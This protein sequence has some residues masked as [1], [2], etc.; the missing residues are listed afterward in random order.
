MYD[1]QAGGMH[2]NGMLSFV[3][4]AFTHTQIQTDTCRQTDTLESA[5]A[6]LSYAAFIIKLNSVISRLVVRVIGCLCGTA[7]MCTATDSL[8]TPSLIF[9]WLTLLVRPWQ[10]DITS[11]C[12]GKRTGVPTIGLADQSVPKEILKI[13]FMQFVANVLPWFYRIFSQSFSFLTKSCP[14]RTSTGVTLHSWFSVW[15][16]LFAVKTIE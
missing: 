12:I 8:I 2:P 1:I 4:R 14:S 10:M 13:N 5:Q 7:H 11:C 16:N 6:L 3:T 15:A 9:H